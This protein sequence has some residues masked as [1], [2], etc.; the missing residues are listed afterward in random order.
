MTVADTTFNFFS[1]LVSDWH[2]VIQNNMR[3]LTNEDEK[4][5]QDYRTASVILRTVGVIASLQA[6]LI[7]NPMIG[8]Y[9]FYD[10][11]QALCRLTLGG[12]VASVGHDSIVVGEAIRFKLQ[13]NDINLEKIGSLAQQAFSFLRK[14]SNIVSL[15]KDPTQTGFEKIFLLRNTWLLNLL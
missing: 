12:V 14:P 4:K 2:S 15:L 5:I 11:P 6:F 7:V 10:W 9:G 3:T 8:R 1:T 13:A